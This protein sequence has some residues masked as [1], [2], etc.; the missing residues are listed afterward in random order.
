MI[1]KF[2]QSYFTY[3]VS[4]YGILALK[5]KSLKIFHPDLT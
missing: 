2:W 1:F 3:G 4:T 5:N